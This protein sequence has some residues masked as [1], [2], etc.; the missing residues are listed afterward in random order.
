MVTIF[1]H[2]LCI[3]AKYIQHIQW[4]ILSHIL[5]IHAKHIHHICW[6][7]IRIYAKYIHHIRWHILRIYKTYIQ[8]IWWCIILHILRIYAKNIQ[9][10]CKKQCRNPCKKSDVRMM[11]TGCLHRSCAYW[12]HTKY[13]LL[14]ALK[15]PYNKQLL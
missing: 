3:Y 5:R 10:G 11:S 7:I 8:Y 6:H 4:H 12:C 2:I 13:L 15:F 1:L 9:H 14:K